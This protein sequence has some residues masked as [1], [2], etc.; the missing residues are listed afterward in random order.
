M[1]GRKPPKVQSGLARRR[2]SPIL[3][4]IGSFLQ[5]V[6]RFFT[7]DPL[8]TFLL[9][10]SV[11]LTIA[12][13][14]LLGSLSPGRT[15][16]AYP[17]SRVLQL[18]QQHQIADA[19]LLD[20][21]ARVVVDTYSGQ[22][23]YANY[24]T[25]GA[26]TQQLVTTL[27]NSGAR[28]VVDAQS[29]KPE[30]QILVQF[31]IPIVLLVCLFA[32]FTRLSADGGAGGIAAFSKFTGKGR[33]KGKGTLHTTTFDDVAG[34][35]DAVA[36]LREIRDYLADPSKYLRVGAAAPKGV[37]LVGYGED[38]VGQGGGRGGRRRVLLALGV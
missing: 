11:A 36:E 5:G 6:L 38:A 22:R 12:F 31:L 2:R 17:L 1:A 21:D 27:T 4:G 25:S 9:L 16:G 34:A 14:V 19:T 23:F 20:H 18:A 3:A 8:S 35:G 26:A 32:Y 30:R 10:A 28:V 29:G 24:P 7:K 13:F 37:L 15:G 33:R